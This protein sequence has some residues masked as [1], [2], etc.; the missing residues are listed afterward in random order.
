[1]KPPCRLEIRVNDELVLDAGY[2]EEGPDYRSVHPPAKT[3]FEQIIDYLSDKPEPS[4]YSWPRVGEE[5]VAAT[6]VC[7]RWG[8]YLA[9]L[10][11]RDK[12]LWSKARSVGLSRIHD[13]EMARINIEAS[14]AL[15]RWIELMRRSPERYRRLVQLAISH[16]PMTRQ[17]T[18][19]AMDPDHLVNLARPST[20][21]QLIDA[22]PPL[23][24]ENAR[25]D[26]QAHP[27][28]VLANA[29]TNFCWRNGPV[30]DIHAGRLS[31]YPLMQ[32]RIT[33][34]EE[35]TLI[36]EAASRLAQGIVA[37]SSLLYEKSERTWSERILPFHLVPFWLVTPKSWSFELQ[38][39]DLRLPEFEE[40]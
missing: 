27:T 19:I 28:R 34:S 35:R 37:T 29:M 18:K 22:V 33:P 24:L 39:S 2:W 20:A 1:M 7:L 40:K 25:A 8:S 26:V 16:L 30:E 13:S 6:A 32:R 38:T 31:A 36:R 12:R 14:A 23:V 21:S 11:D 17:N 15:E 9:V 4:A 10:A 5:A 3:M